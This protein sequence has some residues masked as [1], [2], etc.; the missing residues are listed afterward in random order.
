MTAQ[1]TIIN[2]WLERSLALDLNYIGHPQHLRAIK[3]W[4]ENHISFF[5]NF[6]SSNICW[7][8][9]CTKLIHS[10]THSLGFEGAYIIILVQ[11]RNQNIKTT[12]KLIKCGS[13]LI[14]VQKILMT[15]VL[16]GFL[17]R[18]ASQIENLSEACL[19]DIANTGIDIVW[20]ILLVIISIFWTF[21]SLLPH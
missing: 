9:R 16:K 7:Y 12:N 18:G 19:R 13:K 5:H 11:N 15:I 10:K 4:I 14:K 1:N 20:L 21:I 8:L 6:D 2:F 17:R 3:R